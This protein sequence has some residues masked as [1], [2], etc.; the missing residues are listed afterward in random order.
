M[1]RLNVL[2]DVMP[3]EQREALKHLVFTMISCNLTYKES[4]SS[5]AS[6]GF[7]SV[8]APRLLEPPIDQLLNFEHES[9]QEQKVNVS[10][11]GSFK[12]FFQPKKQRSDLVR[13]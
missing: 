12:M 7:Y 11:K 6:M 10:N 4:T 8:E 5:F 3:D 13:F 2:F 9:E 1:T